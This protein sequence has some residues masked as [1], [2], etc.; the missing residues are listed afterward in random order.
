LADGPSPDH[1]EKA[2]AAPG[3][4]PLRRIRPRY[5]RSLQRR[6]YLSFP[7]HA[8]NQGI[9]ILEAAAAGK[10]VIVRDL[11]AYRDWL[12]DGENC[13]KASDADGFAD[14]LQRLRKDPDLRE[15]LVRQGRRTAEENSLEAVGREL[16]G[17]Y[18]DLLDRPR[19]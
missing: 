5:R 3:Q 6:R 2:P 7:S 13:L 12:F 1:E 16:E 14:C 17:I 19:G 18:R 10:P 8:E 11:P 15:R 9:P 4:R